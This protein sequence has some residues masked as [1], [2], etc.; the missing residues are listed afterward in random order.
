[1]AGADDPP[2]LEGFICPICKSD[3]GD[4]SK[5]LF[6]FEDVHSEEQDFIK[7]FK[8]LYDKAKK[9]ILKQDTPSSASLNNLRQASTASF[10]Y[11]HEPQEIGTTR[12]RKKK[13]DAIRDERMQRLAVPTNQLI[14][15]LGKLLEN[16]P[17]DPLKRK[18]HEQN[19]VAW[20]DGETVDRCP[21]CAGSFYLARRKHHCRTCGSIMC[22]DCSH[23]MSLNT[24]RKILDRPVEEIPQGHTEQNLRLCIH[25]ISLLEVR[26]EK[27]ESRNAKPI[28]SQFYQR[29][30]EY[31]QQAEDLRLQYLKMYNSL[32]NGESIY[33]LDE[34]QTVKLKLLKLAENIDALSSKIAVLGKGTEKPPQGQALRLQNM[35]RAASA[36]YLKTNLLSLPGLPTE[37]Q[38]AEAQNKR[39]EAINARIHEEKKRQSRLSNQMNS[40]KSGPSLPKQTSD[41]TVSLGQGWVPEKTKVNEYDDPLIEQINIIRSYIKEAKAAHKYDEVASLEENLQEL[42]KEFWKKQTQEELAK[43]GE[44]SEAASLSSYD[45][46]RQSDSSH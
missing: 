30:T 7:S 2:V 15:R 18:A 41:P 31:K 1:M 36:V 17:T 33:S 38:F 35:V 13:F 10:D 8:D 43:S 40:V 37:E 26:E 6:H 11:S 4:A 29:L 45:E 22:N 23:F 25:C 20:L 9:K 3:L 39:R 5:L 42:K 27:R 44:S 46:V 34:A 12:S 28:I 16:M 19:T 14:I 21:N 24:A 32:T